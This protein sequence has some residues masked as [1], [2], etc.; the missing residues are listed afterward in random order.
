MAASDRWA[1]PLAGSR[2]VTAA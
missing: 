2:A 1:P